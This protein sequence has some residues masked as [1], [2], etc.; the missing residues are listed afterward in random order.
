MFHERLRQNFKAKD[1]LSLQ[2]GGTQQTLPSGK[3]SPSTPCILAASHR[4]T[5]VMAKEPLRQTAGLEDAA[6]LKTP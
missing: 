4:L 5:S 2:L 3:G 6:S 1:M